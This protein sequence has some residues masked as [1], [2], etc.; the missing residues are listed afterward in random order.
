[1]KKKLLLI[2]LSLICVIAC[3]IGIA[4]CGEKQNLSD[5][6]DGYTPTEGLEYKATGNIYAVSG[7]GTATDT[8]IYIAKKH[9][10]KDVTSI[11]ES[12]FEDCNE[13]TS[14][15]IPNGVTYIEFSA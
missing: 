3:A 11:A 1:M 10:G 6:G 14:V 7:I 13:I 15:T 8:D 2:I 5:E 4:A 9:K 12:A